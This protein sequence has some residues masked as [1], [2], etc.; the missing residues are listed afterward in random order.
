MTSEDENISHTCFTSCNKRKITPK[1]NL[2]FMSSHP[3]LF[4]LFLFLL[5]KNKKAR[6]WERK[7]E[8]KRARKKEGFGKSTT[9]VFQKMSKTYNP[10]LNSDWITW[11]ETSCEE[12]SFLHATFF[13]LLPSNN[14]MR[15]VK[16]SAYPPLHDCSTQHFWNS[17]IWTYQLSVMPVHPNTFA[18][19][20]IYSYLA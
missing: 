8:R 7:Q 9:E 4:S 15:A 14:L 13:Q 11:K 2:S 12:K 18:Y 5:K 10:K 17:G 20:F 16:Y 1:F 19:V 3:P 6:K